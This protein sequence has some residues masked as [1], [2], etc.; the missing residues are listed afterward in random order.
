MISTCGMRK[1]FLLQSGVIKKI[2]GTKKGSI[3]CP[4]GGGIR[5]LSFKRGVTVPF[6]PHAYMRMPVWY[7]GI[8]KRWE[9]RNMN[10]GEKKSPKKV[11]NFLGFYFLIL[12]RPH[13]GLVF[14]KKKHN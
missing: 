8:Q 7:P 9:S 5:T 4:A 10:Y 6:P 2:L 3:K 1:I 14:F 11:I 12:S 13:T